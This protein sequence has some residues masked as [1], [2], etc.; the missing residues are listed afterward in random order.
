MH[1]A[2]DEIPG[3]INIATINN[4]TTTWSRAPK[5]E[6]MKICKDAIYALHNTIDATGFAPLTG[7]HS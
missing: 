2:A 7:I 3:K 1:V 5:R 4:A 6:V